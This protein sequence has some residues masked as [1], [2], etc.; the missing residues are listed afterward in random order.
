M[1]HK[2]MSTYLTYETLMAF[3][4]KGDKK[5][6]QFYNEWLQ[7]VAHLREKVDIAMLKQILLVHLRKSK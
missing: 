2:P 6:E 4:R 3:E 7:M 1:T 5:L